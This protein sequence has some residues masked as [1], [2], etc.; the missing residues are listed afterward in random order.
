MS[1]PIPLSPFVLLKTVFSE[2]LRDFPGTALLL[3]VLL[4]TYSPGSFLCNWSSAHLDRSS[5]CALSRVTS[6]RTQIPPWNQPLI[7]ISVT[8]RSPPVWLL[9][10][11]Y[12]R[13][14][15]LQENSGKFH[16]N[17]R[18]FSIL[19]NGPLWD[20]LINSLLL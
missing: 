18:L 4:V 14:G 13:Y 11:T 20:T 3:R 16:M 15:Q 10:L 9:L 5:L 7:N 12:F 19:L 8:P 2:V 6:L 1:R 17:Q